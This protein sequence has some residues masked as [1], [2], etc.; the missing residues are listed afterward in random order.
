MK[1]FPFVMETKDPAH[2][3]KGY[4]AYGLSKCKD[5]AIGRDAIKREI[6]VEIKN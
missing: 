4:N 2:S 6:G 3:C 1:C 5:N